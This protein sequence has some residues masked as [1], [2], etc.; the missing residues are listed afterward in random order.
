MSI[1]N[2]IVSSENDA[3]E[4]GFRWE[5]SDQIKDQII[6][7]IGEVAVHLDDQNKTKLQEE[8]GDLLH[9]VFSLTVFCGLDP[10]ITLTNSV[11]KFQRRLDAVKALAAEEGLTSLNGKSFD[12]LMHYWKRAKKIESHT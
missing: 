11:T 5:T 8:I 7:E 12:E 2:K 3:S 10:E 1:F 4:F 6:S 9:A